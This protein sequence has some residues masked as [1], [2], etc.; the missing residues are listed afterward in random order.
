VVRPIYIGSNTETALLKFAKSLSWAN[1]KGIHDA[2]NIIQGA[3]EIL[4]QKYTCHVVKIAMDQMRMQA[5][6]VLRQH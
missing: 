3:S 1:Y 2:A 6:A 5:A 4:T